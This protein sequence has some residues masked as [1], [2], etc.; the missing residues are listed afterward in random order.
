MKLAEHYRMLAK[1]RFDSA[2]AIRFAALEAER[3][4][5]AKEKAEV[6]RLESEGEKYEQESK[7]A[8]R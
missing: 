1:K 3:P 7:A 6:A 4:M 8:K 5:D 2:Q